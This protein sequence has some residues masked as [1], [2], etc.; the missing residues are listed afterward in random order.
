MVGR[1]VL[2]HFESRSDWEIIALSRRRPDFP[3]RA[4]CVSVDLL[5]ASE[6]V[7]KLASLNNVTHAVY[8]ALYKS[9]SD[10]SGWIDADHIAGNLAMLQNFLDAIEPSSSSFRHL[11]LLQGTKAYGIHLGAMTIPG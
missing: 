10:P 3:T 4:E 2:T 8:A 6:C 7:A 11:S 5:D 9:T 1:A